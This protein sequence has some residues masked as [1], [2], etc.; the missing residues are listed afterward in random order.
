MAGDHQDAVFK[1]AHLLVH[2]FSAAALARLCRC[3]LTPGSHEAIKRGI[4]PPSLQQLWTSFHQPHCPGQILTV[5]ARALSKHISRDETMTYWGSPNTYNG[6]PGKKNAMADANLARLLSTAVWI[7]THMLPHD[8]VAYEIRDLGGYGARWII[9]PQEDSTPQLQQQT[10]TDKNDGNDAEQTDEGSSDTTPTKE[11]KSKKKWTA[12]R[13]E[14]RGFLE[15]PDPDGHA[16][17]WHH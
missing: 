15:P 16:A 14:F 13:C 10:A 2:H 6:S 7:N 3:R 8:I 11:E 1:V 17:G 9:V 4:C 12:A 5:G